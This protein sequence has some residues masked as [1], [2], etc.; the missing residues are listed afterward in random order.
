MFCKQI[1]VPFEVY[2]FKDN[3]CDNPFTYMG[4]EN[5]IGGAQVVLRNFLSSR[6]KVE[7]MN[8]AMTALW[9]A[10][11]RHWL[12]TDGMGGTP[13]NDAILI[14]PKIVNDFRVKN[15]LEI[16]NTIFLTDGGSNGRSE[17][18]TSEL[19]SH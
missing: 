19:Q 12:Q 1:G 14:A 8:F 3:D 16:V 10:S 17:E 11:D 7:E 13:L 4:Q 18:H 5:V 15:K 6:M 2:A 9:A